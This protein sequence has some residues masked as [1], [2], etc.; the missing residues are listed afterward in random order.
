MTYKKLTKENILEAL[1]YIDKNGVPEKNVN[2][3]YEMVIEERYPPKYVVSVANYLTNGTDISD[4]TFN[5][6]EANNLL[7][8]LGFEIHEIDDGNEQKTDEGRKHQN[9]KVSFIGPKNKYSFHDA[10]V[11]RVHLIVLQNLNGQD[12][13]YC[14][15]AENKSP[16]AQKLVEFLS[17]NKYRL[18]N[19]DRLYEKKRNAYARDKNVIVIAGEGDSEAFEEFENYSSEIIVDRLCKKISEFCLRENITVV[20]VV[21]LN[22]IGSEGSSYKVLTALIRPDR[23]VC[24]ETKPVPEFPEELLEEVME[25]N[26]CDMEEAEDLIYEDD[27][28]WDEISEALFDET[29][30]SDLPVRTFDQLGI[31]DLSELDKNDQE[32]KNLVKQDGV[33]VDYNDYLLAWYYF[34]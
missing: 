29:C 34:F 25:E 3:K 5:S 13:N 10:S 17:D 8:S 23:I 24:Y 1:D 28:H 21:D 20:S 12:F 32:F 9:C 11:T 22:G 15:V 18:E 4:D 26:D 30:D 19:L 7:K 2:K 14:S 33:I 16:V 27:S 31:S 6:I